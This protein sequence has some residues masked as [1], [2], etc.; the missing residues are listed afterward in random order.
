MKHPDKD[1]LSAIAN[2]VLHLMEH[3]Q[4]CTKR[5]TEISIR[6]EAVVTIL[7]AK[8]AGKEKHHSEQKKSRK[9]GYH[10][11]QTKKC[12]LHNTSEHKLH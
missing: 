1:D 4:N 7:A 8:W 3:G 2:A 12:V 10:G 9:A 11:D 6:D 5:F